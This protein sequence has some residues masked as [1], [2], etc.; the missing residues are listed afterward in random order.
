MGAQPKRGEKPTRKTECDARQPA[1]QAIE[2]AAS[3]ETGVALMEPM[4]EDDDEYA[5]EDE[6]EPISLEDFLGLKA[7]HIVIAI[8]DGG[9]R[10]RVLNAIEACAKALAA[11]D[12]IDL[13]P[14]ELADLETPNVAA[15]SAL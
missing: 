6:V 1:Y 4:L 7:H 3:Q 14:H 8:Q 11:V 12:D 15:W 10:E 9:L 2:L 13:S 5:G